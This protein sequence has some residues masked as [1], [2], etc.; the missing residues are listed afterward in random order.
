MQFNVCLSL[1]FCAIS[2]SYIG[3][4]HFVKALLLLVLSKPMEKYRMVQEELIQ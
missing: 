3:H 1:V 2:I 4:F